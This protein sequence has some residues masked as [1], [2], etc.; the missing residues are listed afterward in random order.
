MNIYV[1]G[2]FSLDKK[3]GGIGIALK[4][5]NKVIKRLTVRIKAKDSQHAEKLAILYG[6]LKLKQWGINKATIITD[7]SNLVS[8]INKREHET[9]Q[10]YKSF[11]N[12]VKNICRDYQLNFRKKYRGES[13]HA[14]LLA[15]GAVVTYKEII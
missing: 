13:N 15:T 1:D 8:I 14:H 3:I 6:I 5:K 12:S 7:N 11:Y 2:G 10:K 4:D 9:K